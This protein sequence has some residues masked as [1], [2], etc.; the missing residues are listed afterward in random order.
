MD[1][2]ATEIFSEI[3]AKGSDKESIADKISSSNTTIAAVIDGLNNRSAD[4]RFG[5]EK[6]L[7]FLSQH[8]PAQVY[9]YFDRIAAFLTASN[10]ILRWGAT[11]TLANLAVVDKDQ[12]LP[13]ILDEYLKSISGPD[14]ITAANIIR[15]APKIAW[16]YPELTEKI[17]HEILKV[18]TAVYK[19]DEC[20]NVA[21]G[22][23]LDSFVDFYD[24]IVDK[25]LV[26]QFAARQL[27]NTRKTVVT[28][29]NMLLKKLRKG[30]ANSA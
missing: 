20:R 3:A 30:R 22:H 4:V 12:K 19:T 1:M 5:C 17:V 21:I 6:V 27:Q 16:A 23:A 28:R 11:M 24:L 25:S 29:A 2:I 18:E 8:H 13:S 9:P 7:R 14:M 26:I 15:S 10:K